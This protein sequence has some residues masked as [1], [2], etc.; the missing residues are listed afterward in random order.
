MRR[1]KPGNRPR[2]AF[3]IQNVGLGGHVVDDEPE[4]V[5]LDEE[6]VS[7]RLEHED[8]RERLRGVVVGLEMG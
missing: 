4:H 7:V 3:Q 8:L 1:P 6:A 5:V 2:P